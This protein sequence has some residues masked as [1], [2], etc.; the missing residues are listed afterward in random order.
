M[1][2]FNLNTIA[3]VSLGL[4]IFFFAWS[5]AFYL[6]I[7]FDINSIRPW[8]IIVF[9][10][11]YGFDPGYMA[12][13]QISAGIALIFSAIVAGAIYLSRPKHYFGDARW[14]H[15]GEIKK[16]DLINQSGILVGQQ[17]STY[18][19]NDEPGHLLVAAPT[20]SGKGVG[21]V[22]PNLLSWPGSVIVLD[23]KHENHDITSGFRQQHGQKV[24][25]WSPADLDAKSHRYNFLDAITDDP[26][27]RVSEIQQLATILLADP[28]PGADP[29]WTDEARSL[30]LG[31]VLYVLDTPS[32]PR[33]LGEVYRTMNTNQDLGDVCEHLVKTRSHEL[34]PACIMSLN[35]F[36]KKAAK[37]RSGVK[38]N[39]T[40]SLNFW[41]NP[42]VDAATSASDFDLRDLRRKPMSIYVAIKKNQLQT[43]SR[44][45]NL[46][47]QQATNILQRDLPGTEEPYPVLMLIDEFAALGRMDVV[48][49]S[50]ADIGGYGVRMVNIL[51]GL[52]QL[53]Q[54]YTHQGRESILQN[55][56]L[57]V[58][59]AAN[60]DTTAN[61]VSNRLG[62]KTIKTVSQTD[63]GGLRWM[64]KSSSYTKRELM[65]AD[66]VRRLD[67]DKEIIFK[68]SSRPVLSSKIRY[69]EDRTFK[70]RLLPAADVPALELQ[71]IRP[72][73]F[74]MPDTSFDDDAPYESGPPMDAEPEA[75]TEDAA[76]LAELSA[77]AG[78]L[79]GLLAQEAE[80]NADAATAAETLRATL[81]GLHHD[82]DR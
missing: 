8:S 53:D 43:F 6:L 48:A 40:A 79:E 64:S 23:I 54:L 50:L 45:L 58:F 15:S 51:Q 36:A 4:L 55:S 32:V 73:D 78:E 63:P 34:H 14:A 28:G 60:D 80:E 38:S 33:T 77:L 21:I 16:A 27:H 47:F 18:L 41:A 75:S 19:R 59:F 46:F 57:Q 37:E 5:T 56:A 76:Q 25:K 42:V 11:H 10:Y 31:I 71:T 62:F 9:L 65:N 81:D 29:M 13:L 72:R 1:D 66:E 67:T 22:I 70:S 49:N 61:Y 44:L 68:E 20:R 3:A 17:G 30:F 12:D 2:R 7:G 69:Y 26:A 52:G 74:T 82:F 35:N 24:F 39:L